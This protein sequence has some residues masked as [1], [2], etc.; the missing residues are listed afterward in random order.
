MA[1]TKS[2]PCRI[3]WRWLIDGIFKLI[4]SLVSSDEKGEMGSNAGHRHSAVRALQENKQKQKKDISNRLY[5]SS[6]DCFLHDIFNILSSMWRRILMIK[7]LFG[8]VF[9][10]CAFGGRNEDVRFY[11]KEGERAGG[12]F[13]NTR[14]EYIVM[15]LLYFLWCCCC[16]VLLSFFLAGRKLSQ[17]M[18]NNKQITG[19]QC[20]QLPPCTWK[21]IL[22]VC[23]RLVAVVY[24]Y[25]SR[26]FSHRGQMFLFFIF[27]SS[28]TQSNLIPYFFLPLPSWNSHTHTEQRKKKFKR[29]RFIDDYKWLEWVWK[30]HRLISASR[31]YTVVI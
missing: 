31:S 14:G 11:R 8:H 6:F 26:Q 5:S 13:I 29:S 7:N 15:F 20:V 21:T 2:P 23:A 4:Q 25:A 17:L 10:G 18:A 9:A 3:C 27:P 16:C 30:F 28:Y 22:H 12:V 1:W 19:H 24:I